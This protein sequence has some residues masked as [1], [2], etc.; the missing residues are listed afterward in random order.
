MRRRWWLVAVGWATMAGAVNPVV[1]VRVDR[2]ILSLVPTPGVTR[3]GLHATATGFAPDA[4]LTFAWR[5]V[6]DAL[7]PTAA[8]M[9]AGKLIRFGATDAPDVVAEFPDWGVYEARVTVTD[10]AHGVSASANTWVS[11]WD[12]RSHLVVDGRAD[13]LGV[14]P[15]I[16]PPPSVRALSPDPGPFVHPRLYCADADW[17][18]LHARCTNGVL[19]SKALR[20]MQQDVAR[21][22][23][24]PNSDF[25]KLTAQLL[26]GTEPD[27]GRYKGKL[28]DYADLLRDACFVAWVTL[29]PRT[30]HDQ[31]PA[32]EQA[33]RRRL[34]QAVATL[35]RLQ[36]RACWDRETGA[37]HK[38]SP[39]WIDGLDQPGERVGHLA[40]L[41][42][43]YDFSAPW[44]T[45]DEQRAVRDLLF[46]ACVG[47]T[48]GARLMYTTRNG[49]ALNHGVERGLQQNGDFMNIEEERIVGALAIAGE[50]SEVDPRV[51]SF[52]T[53]LPKPK[54]WAKSGK[55][56]PCDWV[57]RAEFD[58]GR[59]HEASRPYPVGSTWPFAR[60][61]EIDNL[62]RAIWWND[63]VYVS[64]WGFQ[65]NKEAYYG[66]SALGLWPAAVAYA[67]HG[68]V[69]QFVTSFY[70]HTSLAL[71]Y[72]YYPGAVTQKSDHFAS[73]IYM[74]DHHDGGGDYRQTHVLLLK[75]MYPDDPLVDYLYAAN[76]P[77]FE[78]RVFIP[79]YT[80]LWGLD[81][82]LN[83][84][85]T[86]LAAAARSAGLPLTKLDPEQGLVVARSGWDESDALLYFDEGWLATGH[87]HAEK[88]NFSFYALGRPWSIPP[89]YHIVESNY[90]SLV[91]IQDPAY[92]D[93]PVTEGYVGESPSIIPQG[94]PYPKCF[95]TPPGQL[96][97]VEDGPGQVYT[98]MAGDAKTAYDYCCSDSKQNVPPAK[99]RSEHAY[100][101]VIDDMLSRWPDG[102]YVFRRNRDAHFGFP[103]KLTPG[104]NP[105]RY[106]FRTILFVRGP[107]P[108][109]LIVDDIRKDDTPR[110]YRWQLNCAN[111]F[112]PPSGC[113]AD[114]KGKPVAFSLLLAAGASATDATLLHRPD[115]GDGPGLPRLLL[116]DVS[117]LDNSRQPAI[118]QRTQPGR[119][120]APPACRLFVD[121]RGVVE[122]RYKVLL[123]PYRTGEALPATRWEGRTLVIDL[124][125]GAVD[126]ITCDEAQPDHRTRLTF[127]RSGA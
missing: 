12:Y 84:R 11:V 107:R 41:A 113:F 8:S 92:A 90:Q 14:A 30:P 16:N 23:D 115:Q 127:S 97:S 33:R 125:N 126:R 69:N 60:K 79:F 117:E 57:Q 4:R 124:R 18:E 28:N 42:L 44:M 89:G 119:K 85:P 72:N 83:G 64:P 88:N 103:D 26:A 91:S 77:G 7:S 67:R 55:V 3:T 82:G 86:T 53:E 102:D 21:R 56:F 36:L 123:F 35:A 93:D 15:G 6:Q 76:A 96:L 122:P 71:L 54:D 80:A 68:A 98:L 59:E 118:A 48:T 19:A 47:R 78:Q 81:P 45:A 38:D 74:Y 104:Y 61:A 62:Q 65:L 34:A 70:Y 105:V 31:A 52:F 58:G 51:V 95:P 116:R 10:T 37:F 121:R 25:A 114:E 39:L 46:A 43:A 73:N 108:Y 120:D 63:D 66:F 50:D 111:A 99:P 5:Q 27:W 17:P 49:V 109:A 87:M 100:P 110:N 112:G 2:P 1:A 75:Y 106:A 20:L 24:A 32:D 40:N 29:D 13:P 101:G 9:A 94:S 22:L